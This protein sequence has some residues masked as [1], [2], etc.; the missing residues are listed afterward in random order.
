[1]KITSNNQELI[2]FFSSLRLP[3]LVLLEIFSD[4]IYFRVRLQCGLVVPGSSGLRD[5]DRPHSLET[6]QHL[7]S[8]RHDPLI[9]PLLASNPGAGRG[10]QELCQEKLRIVLKPLRKCLFW[11]Y[12]HMMGL[13]H[14]LYHF[15]KRSINNGMLETL[16]SSLLQNVRSVLSVPVAA[17]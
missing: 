8:L 2:Y 9:P 4:L 6:L 10:G 15:G 3:G 1:M 16:L 12:H 14:V 17:S 5:G 11:Q 7:H 13:C